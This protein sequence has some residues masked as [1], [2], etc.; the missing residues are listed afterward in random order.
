[1]EMSILA[2]IL[3]LDASILASI[4]AQPDLPDDFVKTP[5]SIAAVEPKESHTTPLPV[6]P[7]AVPSIRFESVAQAAPELKTTN[8]TVTERWLVSE[9]WCANCPA[10][11]ARFLRDGGKPGNII[12]IAEAKSRHGKIIPAIPAE[13]TTQDFVTYVQPPT[14]RF[15]KR[16]QVQLDND[17]TPSKNAIVNHLRKGGPHQGKHWQ[18]W[19]LESWDKEQLYALHDDDHAGNVPTFEPEPVVSA[20][21]SNATL[22]PESI[23]AA[24]SAHLQRTK[25]ER[26]APQGLFDITIDTPDSARGWIADMLTKQS[27]EFPSAGVSAQWGGD[28]TI[29]IAPGKLRISPGAIVSAKKFGVSVT[30]T[31]TGVT[32][33]DDLSWVTL[34]LKGVPDLTVRFE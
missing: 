3:V 33:A 18:A 10:A 4:A 2:L 31:L 23:A 5:G 1:M 9:D 26:I 24:L 25:S 20:I 11:K 30:T 15:A 7:A 29:S 34:E 14:Y 17:S 19:H 12:T 28:R 22:S 13:F 16:M 8:V 6:V 27:V 21:L 32:F